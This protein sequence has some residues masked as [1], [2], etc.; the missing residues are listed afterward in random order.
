MKLFAQLATAAAAAVSCKIGLLSNFTYAPFVHF[1][2]DRLDIN[3]HFN[4]IVISEENGW[5]KPSPCI[6]KDILDRLHITDVADVVYVGD[7]P[8]EDIKGAKS[9]GFKTV[10]VS[11]QF[12]SLKN[13]VESNISADFTA[14]NLYEVS[15]ILNQIIQNR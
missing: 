3:K 10:F 2:L 6:F 11:S 13:L 12:H 15:V 7:S 8:L 4:A 9:V 1:S 5:R 14:K